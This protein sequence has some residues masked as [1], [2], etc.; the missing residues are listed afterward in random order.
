MLQGR[1][2]YKTTLWILLRAT[3]GSVVMLIFWMLADY[4][5]TAEIWQGL[6]V[7]KSA[8]VVEYCELNHPGRFFHQPMNSY[9]NLIYFFIGLVICQWAFADKKENFKES[10]K[11]FWALSLMVGL[12]F[13]YL[14]FGSTFFHA[15]LTWLGQR[16]DMNATYGLTISLLTMGFVAVFAPQP[17]TVKTQ[18]RILMGVSLLILVF[19]PLSLYVSS[20]LLLPL[21]ILLNLL[22]MIVHYF[23][24]KGQ[25]Q[26]VWVI[27]S[28]FLIVIAI[29]IRTLDVQK[30]GCDPLSI[31]QGHAL[32]HLLTALS[33]FCTFIFYRFNRHYSLENLFRS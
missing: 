33:S 14:S 2:K 9:S 23:Q 8:L 29:K 18:K 26:I 25:K 27:L 15:S 6:Q 32:W 3:L 22:L 16:V 28:F 1:A 24:R 10:V 31:W 13:I 12:S 11:G 21:M 30:I 4:Y 17:I 5:L 7:S 20:Q 19:Y